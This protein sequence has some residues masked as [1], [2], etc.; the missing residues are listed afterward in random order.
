MRLLEEAKV[1]TVP[2]AAFGKAGEGHLRL[3][4][5]PPLD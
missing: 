1:L 5:T 4:S 2:G 3:S